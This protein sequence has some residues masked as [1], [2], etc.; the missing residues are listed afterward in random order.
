MTVQAVAAIGTGLTEQT[1][2]SHSYIDDG[3]WVKV[4]GLG[5][6]G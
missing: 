6:S 4:S 2:S 5:Q 3:A 1:F